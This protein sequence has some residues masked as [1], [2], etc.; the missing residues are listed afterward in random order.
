MPVVDYDSLPEILMRVGVTGRWIAGHEQGAANTGV[1][2]NWV[3]PGIT[4]PRHM[5]EYEEVV[6]IEQ[7]EAWV[8]VDGVRHQGKP[9]RAIIIPARAIH[10]WGTLR[11][12]GLGSVRCRQEHLPG[13]RAANRRVTFLNE[14][15]TTIRLR[16][17][18]RRSPASP[19]GRSPAQCQSMAANRGR[20]RPEN[21]HRPAS[22][23]H[24][25]APS[26]PC[27]L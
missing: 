1:L 22:A 13:W 18:W 19:D 14:R 9:G 10:A 5:H 8:E 17:A 23:D 3:E 20:A 2:R 12:K 27:R 6:L 15:A 4:I 25:A 11:E 7:G 16:Y 21:P 26:R 24:R